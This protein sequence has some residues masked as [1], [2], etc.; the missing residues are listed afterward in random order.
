[1]WLFLG[2]G[3]RYQP[4]PGGREMQ[5]HCEQCARSTVFYE[6][7]V[8]R[9][10]SLYFVDLAAFDPR[11]VM[12]CGACGAAFAVDDRVSPDTL[13]DTQQGTALGVLGSAAARAQQAVADGDVQRKAEELGDAASE[14]WGRA[15]RSVGEW[16]QRKTKKD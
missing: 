4:V 5:R 7:K 12:A 1:M 15:R 6:K 9:T 10:V 8:S 13:G 14:A 11:Y 2:T 16:I 3:K